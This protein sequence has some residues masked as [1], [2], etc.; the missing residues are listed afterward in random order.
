[1]V[2]EVDPELR[3]AVGC[4]Q[5]GRAEARVGSA[6]TVR[7]WVRQAEVDAGQRPGATHRGVGGTKAAASARTPSCAGPTKSSRRPRL[8]SRPSSTGPRTLVRF[9]AEHAD[10]TD[11][12]LRWG[13]EPICAVLSEHGCP[14]APS[15]YYDAR[16]S[17]GR[18][19]RPA[20]ARRRA[21][22]RDRAGARREL[23]GLRRPQGVAPTQPRRPEPSWVRER[24]GFRP[25]RP[26]GRWCQHTRLPVQL[27][28]CSRWMSGFFRGCTSEPTRLSRVPRRA[29]PTSSCHVRSG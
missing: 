21:A 4:D 1:M 25:P 3:L 5:R 22:R 6:E 23:R 15:T 14:I 19:S 2:V 16:A 28:S 10:R 18:A 8:S 9:I 17:A 24:L 11:G 7:K 20:A 13:V 26:V 12:G 27:A 29:V